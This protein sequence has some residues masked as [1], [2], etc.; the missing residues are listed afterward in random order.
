MIFY[1]TM[2]V[3]ELLV[4]ALF[5]NRKDIFNKLLNISALA[6][7]VI[8]TFLGKGFLW[9]IVPFLLVP[10]LAGLLGGLIGGLRLKSS[11]KQ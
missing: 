4:L 6:T 11:K 8:F 2:W 10:I 7:S 1:I 9:V 3:I 5:D